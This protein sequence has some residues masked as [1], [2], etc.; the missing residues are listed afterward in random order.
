VNW[1]GRGGGRGKR[2]TE[3]QDVQKEVWLSIGIREG[4][5]GGKVIVGSE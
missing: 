2:E 5:I 4:G 1:G 3:I